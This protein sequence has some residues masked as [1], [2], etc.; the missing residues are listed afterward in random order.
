MILEIFHCAQYFKS[1]AIC[2]NSKVVDG[3]FPYDLARVVGR[4]EIF[5]EI[6]GS[7]LKLFGFGNKFF[8]EGK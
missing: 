3:C 5:T 6:R 1:S 7:R 4:F 8:P 2:P